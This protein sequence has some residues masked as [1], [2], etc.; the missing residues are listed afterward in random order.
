MT[1]RNHVPS[2]LNRQVGNMF[3]LNDRKESCSG[4]PE[5]QVGNMFKSNDR[6]DSCSDPPETTGREHVQIK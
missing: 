1:G 5:R 4:P 2:Q 6:K 3:K